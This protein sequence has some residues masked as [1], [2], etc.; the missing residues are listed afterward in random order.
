[1][2]NNLEGDAGI[3]NTTIKLIRY[4]YMEKKRQK[5]PDKKNIF[6]IS[7]INIYIN[8]SISLTTNKEKILS[9]NNCILRLITS[10]KVY[11]NK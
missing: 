11:C 6:D 4:K 10:S 2:T 9:L 7:D 5:K 3:N 1:M 8:F